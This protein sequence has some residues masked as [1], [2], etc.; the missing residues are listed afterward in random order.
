MRQSFSDFRLCEAEFGGNARYCNFL[1]AD[2]WGLAF[3]LVHTPDVMIHRTDDLLGIHIQVFEW[4]IRAEPP[5][6][7]CRCGHWSVVHL[8]GFDTPRGAK[9]RTDECALA[10]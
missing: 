9:E 10:V 3:K 6:R 2:F 7:F 1:D 4:A 8:L 5:E